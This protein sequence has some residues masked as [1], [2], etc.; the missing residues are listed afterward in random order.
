MKIR[1]IL[2]AAA[3][4]IVATPL[5]AADLPPGKWWHRP[6]IAKKLAITEEQQQKLDKIF[7]TAANDLIDM[8]SEVE[9]ATLAIRGELDHAQLNKQNL[10][11][12][13]ERVGTARTRLFT[14]ELMMLAD[15][16]AVLSSEQWTT[17]RSHLDRM[18]PD[19]NVRGMRP[20]GEGRPDGRPMMPPPGGGRPRQ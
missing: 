5:L 6:E 14:R 7:Q 18:R 13:A 19:R 9:K 3:V 20:R 2:A 11:A 15:M 8:R 10:Q 1:S 17:L 12:L 4:L 16:R